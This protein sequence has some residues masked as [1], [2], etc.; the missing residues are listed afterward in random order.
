MNLQEREPDCVPAVLY[1]GESQLCGFP[2]RLMLMNS[3]ERR[4]RM[5]YIRE[6]LG[7][8]LWEYHIAASR[9][10]RLGL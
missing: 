1:V 9:F 4:Q 10:I 7:S 5:S 8:D 2:W 6:D 3:D